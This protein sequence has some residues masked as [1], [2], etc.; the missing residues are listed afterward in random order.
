MLEKSIGGTTVLSLPGEATEN[1]RRRQFGVQFL[2]IDVG[3]G[4]IGQAIH[5]SIDNAPFP[6][7]HGVGGSL[8]PWLGEEFFSV[9]W[10]VGED[11]HRVVL[12]CA[13]TED[14]ACGLG[15]RVA[16]SIGILSLL[17]ISEAQAEMTEKFG[18][19]GSVDLA[20]ILDE[21]MVLVRSEDFLEK[22]DTVRG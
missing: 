17:P 21:G 11:M 20:G 8:M 3:R 5:R 12:V 19:L 14:L 13:C 2:T 15:I 1:R 10:P 18:K 22:E 7:G 9:G 4:N 6:I 16:G